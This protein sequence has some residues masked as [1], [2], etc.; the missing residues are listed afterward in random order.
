[1]LIKKLLVTILV[2]M[3]LPLL[4]FA[5]VTTSSVSGT[6]LSGTGEGLESATVT[7]VHQPTGTK[8]VTLSKK[9]GTFTLPGLRPGGPY[10]LTTEFIGFKKQETEIAN[11]ALG[12]DF[13][14]NVS[15][16]AS[17]STLTEVTVTAT[18]ATPLK[19]GVA[20]NVG[21]REISTLP[22]ISR[23]LTDFTR[24]TPQANGNNIAGRDARYNNVTI[25]G[26]N[27][28]NNFGLSTDP[29]PGGGSNPISIDAI[30]QLT[31]NVAPYD[32]RQSNFTGGNIAATTK[33]G[34][35]TF[36][37]TA[38]TFWRNQNQIGRRVGD[39]MLPEQ[40]MSK[41]NIYGGSLGGPIIKN[42]LFFFVNYE[43]EDKTLPP[44]TTYSPTGGSGTGNVSTV[45]IDSL[46]KFSD[47]LRNTYKYETGA[48]DNFPNFHSKNTKFLAK[49]DFNISDIHKL[50]LKYSDL[51]SNNDV[52][53]NSLS[54]PNGATSG[55]NSWTSQ[56]RFGA[57]AMSFAN[58]NYGFLDAVKTGSIELNSNWKGR[59]SNELI[60]TYTKIRDT[61][62][63]PSQVFPFIDIIGPNPYPS[64][65]NNY[66]SAGYEPYSYN[67][68]VKNNITNV[69]D[70]F[71]YYAGRH[72]ITA[73]ASYEQQYVGNMFMPASQSYYTYGSLADFMNPAAHPIA[74]AYT[75]SRVEGQDAVYSAAMKIAQLGLYLQDEF[76]VTPK[77]KVTYGVRF[78]RPIYID[79]PLENPSITAL[80]LAGKNGD[81]THYSTG[82][83]PKSSWYVAP[84]VSVRYDVMKGLTVRGGTGI[85]T[86][87]IPFVY[88]T[89]MPTNSGM[90]QVSALANASQL[91][92]ITFNPNPGA[93]KSLFTAPAPTPNS[94]GF[95]LIDPNYKFPQVWR[96]NVGVDKTFGQGFVFSAD[97]MYSK[98]LNATIMRNANQSNPT[99]TVNLGGSSRPSFTSTAT[100]TRRI[101]NAYANAIVLENAKAGHTFSFTT[102]LAKSFKSGF[103]GS[104]AYTYTVSKD[105]TANPG[106]TASSTWSVNPTS[107]TQNTQELSYSS[108]AVPDRIVGTLSYRKEYLK[109]LATTVSI[110]YEGS[111][112]GR[113]SYIYGA[114]SGTA[115][116]GFSN[117]ADVNYD[118]NSADLMYIPKSPSEITFVPLTV[119]SGTTAVTYTAQQQSDAFFAYVAQ[120][121]YLSKHQGEV[122]QRN[123]VVTPFYNR[124]DFKFLQDLFA[125]VGGKRRNTIQFSVDVTNFLNMLNRNWGLKDF[126][127]VN[128]PLRATKNATTGEVR[129][130]LATYTPNGS[131]T[132]ILLDRTYINSYSTS[133]TWAV[134][135]GLRYI[136]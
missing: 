42:K 103:Y 74:F 82:M 86:G 47:Y 89:N 127:P 73:G 51:K 67:N 61:R 30:D 19:T 101:Y 113:F 115:P 116:T 23:S 41:N 60:G 38:Y 124:V 48:Y 117:T 20:T 120:D 21:Q 3:L 84:R 99:A 8:Y 16:A 76:N 33:S 58:S 1:M 88:L 62:T 56:A 39:L 2:T 53:V 65:K 7:A 15:M 91:A 77:L 135:F 96:S 9:G 18:R 133:S 46:K 17:S 29:L 35:N 75:F 132:P 105:L 44:G 100:A 87:R 109:H 64:G 45:K 111:E 118:G 11:L 31:V 136:F 27:L 95:V 70:N 121:K 126:F 106:S 63:S 92:Q 104:L 12:E 5:Q 4:T 123:G 107:G 102:Q 28:N 93:W 72:T 10:T 81:S 108:F 36:R 112:Q 32:V 119:G 90:Y 83:W 6:I 26:A 69:I 14:L 130:Q 24:L 71:T 125:N 34:T 80:T 97:V 25:D 134:Q 85:F 129:Y 54:V 66:M 122:A 57:N 49:I 43:K 110:F 40:T 13:H 131:S 22:T 52:A 78:D 79:Q 114:A 37:G 94:A 55:T 59:F 68:D 128:N 50:T 98:D